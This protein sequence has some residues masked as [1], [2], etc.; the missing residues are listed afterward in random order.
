MGIVAYLRLVGFDCQGVE[1]VPGSSNRRDVCY[2]YF[3]PSA[4]LLAAVDDFIENR[5]L[6]TPKEY[7]KIYGLV[8]TE[9]F[10]AKDNSNSER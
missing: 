4:S 9:F 1:M 2:W 10:E 7:N 8:R 5:A 3:F 6:V